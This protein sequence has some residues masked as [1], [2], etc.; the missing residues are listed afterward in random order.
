MSPVNRAARLLHASSYNTMKP[1]RVHRAHRFI[2]A[3]YRVAIR[4]PPTA[5]VACI[6]RT[7]IMPA[8]NLKRSRPLL[9]QLPLSSLCFPVN[10]LMPRF[11]RF[12][13]IRFFSVKPIFLVNYD[14]SFVKVVITD[15]S[16]AIRARE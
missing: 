9:A 5:K 8:D 7:S 4:R 10:A 14:F 15:I 16:V 1:A 2:H 3:L 12:R 11:I 6:R 13:S